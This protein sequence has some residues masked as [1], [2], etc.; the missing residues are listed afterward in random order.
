MLRAQSHFLEVSDEG[1]TTRFDLSSLF[2]VE[3]ARWDSPEPG[4]G[5]IE[6][7]RGDLIVESFERIHG[8]DD[9][10]PTRLAARIVLS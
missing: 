9:V 5:G 8:P 10:K 4:L 1:A 2:A 3:R 7:R 6:G